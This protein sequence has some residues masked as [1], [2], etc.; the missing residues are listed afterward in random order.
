MSDDN[1]KFAND[2]MPTAHLT[3]TGGKATVSN[4]LSPDPG[5][6]KLS[7]PTQHLVPAAPPQPSPPPSDSKKS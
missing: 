5:F 7:A 6:G 1:P 4:S 2:S 3:N